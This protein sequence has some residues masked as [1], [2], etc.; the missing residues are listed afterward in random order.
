MSLLLGI[1]DYLPL[2]FLP[3]R[4]MRKIGLGKEMD[5]LR[6]Q[7]EKYLKELPQ[8]I[9]K[10]TQWSKRVNPQSNQKIFK[11][12]DGQ[13]IKLN[14]NELKGATRKVNIDIALKPIKDKAK[15][16]EISQFNYV[17]KYIDNV[18][19]R[20]SDLDNL[21]DN[22]IKSVTGYRF[23]QRPT[24]SLTKTGRQ[25]VYRGA[26]GLNVG[27]AIKNLTQGVNTYSKL[28][29]KYTIKGYWDLFLKGKELEG[30]GLLK[31]N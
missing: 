8:E 13:D 30:Q 17:K 21:I 15:D 6:T 3:D 22:T 31:Q 11:Y 25:A 12:L 7:Y 19:L 28:G 20:P 5:T 1:L 26:L 29:E 24:A 2:I 27:S 10:V 14:T 18:N 4:I 23:G 9:D 16:L